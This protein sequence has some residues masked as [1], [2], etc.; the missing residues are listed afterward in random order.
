MLQAVAMFTLHVPVNN[1]RFA[2]NTAQGGNRRM[3]DEWKKTYVNVQ[4]VT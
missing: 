2:W 3:D 4:Q 1:A